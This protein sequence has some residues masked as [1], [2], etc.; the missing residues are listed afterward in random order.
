M[1]SILGSLLITRAMLI[2]RVYDSSASFVEYVAARAIVAGEALTVDYLGTESLLWPRD[3]RRDHPPCDK[4]VRG[5][6][7]LRLGRRPDRERSPAALSAGLS[8]NETMAALRSLGALGYLHSPTTDAFR[9]ACGR[10]V[11][12]ALGGRTESMAAAIVAERI[13]CA[14]RKE[15]AVGER[16]GK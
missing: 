15:A 13:R 11:T 9:A 2:A 16:D 8:S 5:D 7:A 4:G 6:C 1:P 12:G 14:Q 10:R 3:K